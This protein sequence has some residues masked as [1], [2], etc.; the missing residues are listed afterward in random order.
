[1]R[2]F[3]KSGHFNVLKAANK[4]GPKGVQATTGRGYQVRY[5][6]LL[7]QLGGLKARKRRGWHKPT[8]RPETWGENARPVHFD[9]SEPASGPSAP[10]MFS[11]LS[12]SA[13]VTHT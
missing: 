4:L 13:S 6:S 2:N 8:Q 1:M 5:A 3:H 10:D 7:G 12:A 9:Q 11:T